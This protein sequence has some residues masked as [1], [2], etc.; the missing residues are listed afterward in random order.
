M[1][2]ILV[3]LNRFTHKTRNLVKIDDMNLEVPTLFKQFSW[4][5]TNDNGKFLREIIVFEFC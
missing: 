2:L 4:E 3:H 1:S 5:L